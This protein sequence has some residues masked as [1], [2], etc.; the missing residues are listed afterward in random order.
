[1]FVRLPL[2]PRVSAYH[3]LEGFS[4]H[5][6]L[7]MLTKICRGNDIFSAKMTYKIR[8]C[9]HRKKFRNYYVVHSD[10]CTSTTERKHT[11]ALPRPLWFASA[12]QGYVLCTLPTPFIIMSNGSFIQYMC[13][14][15]KPPNV[16]RQVLYIIVLQKI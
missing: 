1:M 5:F 3:P 15:Y 2:L 9:F 7:E 14:T 10:V 4:L 12:S 6:T 16:K 11:V 8:L 13:M